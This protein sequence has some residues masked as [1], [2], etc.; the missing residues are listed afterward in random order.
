MAG[1]EIGASIGLSA[2]TSVFAELGAPLSALS[3]VAASCTVAAILVAV[4]RY[5]IKPDDE[6]ALAAATRLRRILTAASFLAASGAFFTWL[7]TGT[8]SDPVPGL[9]QISGWFG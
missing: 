4:I 7:V 2:G 1:I 3:G 8:A 6:G 5:Q 9:D